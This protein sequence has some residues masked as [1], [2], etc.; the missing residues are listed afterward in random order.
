MQVV[1]VVWSF[2]LIVNVAS[3]V[4]T[5]KYFDLSYP[6]DKDTIY[7]PGQRQYELLKDYD[8]V[9]K[10]GFTYSAYSFCMGE[11]GGTHLD[12][13][14]HFNANGWTVD[15]IPLANLVDVPAVVIDVENYVNELE[16]P[17]GFA[18]EVAH[19]EAYEKS[20]GII[21]LGSVVLVHTG[22]SK[23]W[24]NK[25]EYLGW[26]N[27]TE[28]LNFPGLSENATKMLVEER[29]IIGIGLDTS[30]VDLG[31]T[32]TFPVHVFLAQ[33]Q[34]FSLENVANL[35][36]LI[37]GANGCSLRLFILPLNIVGGTGAPT[38]I[39]AYCQ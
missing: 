20:H 27:I 29:Q 23:F 33:E 6:F 18:F 3:T 21:P 16:E 13:P 10:E 39:L 35:R 22:W 8:N 25:V 11:H 34:I 38:R 5:K 30:S 37:E 1:T 7:F 4:S 26:D 19:V 32:K 14:V 28:T 36:T 9:P 17:Q 12:A 31:S 15:Q 24:P 2:F